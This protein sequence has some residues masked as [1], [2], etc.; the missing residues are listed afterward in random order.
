MLAMEE[1]RAMSIFDATVIKEGTRDELLVVASLAMRCLN[2]NGR[3]RP[4]MKEVATELEAIR[5]SHIPSTVQTNT[6][7]MIYEKNLSFTTYTET[8]SKMLSSNDSFSQ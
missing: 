6:G 4:T 1:G 2:L 8:S 3:Y 7:P 5:M